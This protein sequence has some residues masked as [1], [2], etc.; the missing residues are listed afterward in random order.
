MTLSDNH[1]GI[2]NLP[3]YQGRNS[4]SKLHKDTNMLSCR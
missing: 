4:K 3:Q 2:Q 1:I